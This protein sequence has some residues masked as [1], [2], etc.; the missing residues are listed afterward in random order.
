MSHQCEYYVSKVNQVQVLKED[1]E[2]A[3]RVTFIAS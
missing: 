1:T 3:L 2:I